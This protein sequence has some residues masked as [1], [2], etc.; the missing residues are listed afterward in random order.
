MALVE[1]AREN[2]A[3]GTN[4][5]AI[6]GAVAPKTNSKDLPEYRIVYFLCCKGEVFPGL[7]CMQRFLR[8]EMFDG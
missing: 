7:F 6:I 8:R 5:E 4:A 2:V 1:I 3:V